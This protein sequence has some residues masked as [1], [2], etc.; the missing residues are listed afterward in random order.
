MA[1][2]AIRKT[3]YGTV[4]LHWMLVALLLVAVATGLRIAINSPHDLAWLHVFDFLLPQSVVWTAHIPVGAALFALAISYTIYMAKTGLTRRIRPDLAR[5]KG[6]AGTS[7]ARYRALN[8]LLYWVLFIALL[9]QMVTGAMLYIGY[10]GWAAET[11]LLATWVIIAYIPAH[12]AVHYAID[13]KSQLLRVLNPGR[14]PP[15]P[16][17]FDPFELIAAGMEA[18]MGA[19]PQQ[20]P[21]EPEQPWPGH[22]WC[23]RA[24]RTGR[25]AITC[26][27]GRCYARIPCRQPSRVALAFSCSCFRSTPRRE[28][29]WSSIRSRKET[30]PVLM[31]TCPIR[32]GAPPSR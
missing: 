32:S 14:L 3:D 4:L 17:E 23:P 22:A 1:R 31:A 26:A 15:P 7:K 29:R 9:I 13:G 12:L 8:V 6:I 30:F 16:E 25:A 27:P 21:R 2:R 20:P 5:L 28:T 19:A 11:H 18:K 24:I 10:G